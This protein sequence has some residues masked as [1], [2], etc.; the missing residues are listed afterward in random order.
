[1]ANDLKIFQPDTPV[2]FDIPAF[3]AFIK[4]NGVILEHFKALPCPLGAVDLLDSRSPHHEHG[5]C[6]NGYL[7]Y[8][9]GTVTATFTNNSAISSLGE[10]GILDGSVVNVTFPR[11]YDDK[12]DK[13][14]YIQLYDRFFIKGC[15]VLVPNSQKVE[16]HL[17]G[18]DKMTY[19]VKQV[20]KVVDSSNK[21]YFDGDFQVVD[22]NIV[23]QR[24]NRPG[25][26]LNVNKG[27]IYSIRYLYSPFFYA[28]RI[29]HEV[30][31]A[32]GS[33][34]MSGEK[35]INRVPY[36]VLLSR[37]YYLHKQEKDDQIEDSRRDLISPRDSVFGPR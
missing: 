12:P 15:E 10:I 32:A 24:Q 35:T 16:A 34:F 20:E 25:F 37:E 4:N 8:C 22:G 26:D 9:A 7:Y 17:T 27:T 3:D 2:R 13:Q 21:E 36:A 28:S 29:I 14:V 19:I 18:T 30:R 33:D 31:V 23:W 11:F 1:M 5:Q 6:S